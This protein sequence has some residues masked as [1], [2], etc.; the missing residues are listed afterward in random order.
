MPPE[1][2][3]NSTRIQRP[4]STS[5]AIQHGGAIVSAPRVPEARG[6]GF[7]LHPSTPYA[8]PDGAFGRL[9]SLPQGVIFRPI[10]RL[11]APRA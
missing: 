8:V 2:P 4:P 5:I 11:L 3:H 1:L 7:A 9:A 10:Y 6:R